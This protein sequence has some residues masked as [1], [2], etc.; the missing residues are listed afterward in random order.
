MPKTF[1]PA[2][3]SKLSQPRPFA[4]CVRRIDGSES[5]TLALKACAKSSSFANA[6]TPAT[7]KT[8]ARADIQ[9]LEISLA[10]PG[11]IRG[12]VDA[13]AF[14]RTPSDMVLHCPQ[15][16]ADEGRARV[17]IET[18]QRDPGLVGDTAQP[19]VAEIGIR[20]HEH[21][22]GREIGLQTH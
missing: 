18:C 9:C 20:I 3:H 13:L 1:L 17:G 2:P 8:V 10:R 11:M 12:M 21:P 5:S 19:D 22:T 16:D 14:A 7:P 4:R 15:Q 6:I